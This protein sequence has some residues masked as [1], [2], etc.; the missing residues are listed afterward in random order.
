MSNDSTNRAGYAEPIDTDRI[1][2]CS[3]CC[4]TGEAGTLGA[5]NLC[6]ECGGDG[7][8]RLE[9]QECEWCGMNAQEATIRGAGHV[10][11][12]CLDCLADA[13]ADP[14]AHGLATLSVSRSLR[15]AAAL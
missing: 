11:N 12:V 2:V 14:F 3:A 1:V 4:G 5:W 6:H 8:L 10:D 13:I 9:D 15:Y 7:E